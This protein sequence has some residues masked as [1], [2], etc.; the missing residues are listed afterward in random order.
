M[1][2]SC[3]VTITLYHRGSGVY[4]CVCVWRSGCREAPGGGC[5]LD[6]SFTLGGENCTGCS[7]M[8]SADAVSCFAELSL[9]KAEC[10][11]GVG[12]RAVC[13]HRL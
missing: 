8:L 12:L 10:G 1:H 3:L 4:V 13:F 11:T 6:A 9:I 5:S 2:N 7:E